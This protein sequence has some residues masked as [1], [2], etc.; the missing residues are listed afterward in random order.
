M[1]ILT[2]WETAAALYHPSSQDEPRRYDDGKLD[3]FWNFAELFFT[4]FFV[5]E[6]VL[7]IAVYG[8]ISYWRDHMNRCAPLSKQSLTS[9][10]KIDT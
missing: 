9:V 7:K 6:A 5:A 8:W 2:I 4:V 1:C 3:S 10:L